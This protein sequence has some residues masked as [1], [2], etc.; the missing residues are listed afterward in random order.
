MKTQALYREDSN[1]MLFSLGFHTLRSLPSSTLANYFSENLKT[2][3][4][5]AS[6]RVTAE[7]CPE[8]PSDSEHGINSTSY[9]NIF[10]S[11]A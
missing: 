4:T 11:R 10:L 6:G 9:A 1:S 2:L 7:G 5:A 8:L 3:P